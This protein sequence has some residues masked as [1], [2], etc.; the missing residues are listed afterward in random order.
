MDFD[1]Y[2]SNTCYS[3]EFEHDNKCRIGKAITEGVRYYSNICS[4]GRE[5]HARSQP[6][7]VSRID[8]GSS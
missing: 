1:N 4:R 3:V 8:T 5:N 7:L 6:G 2:S